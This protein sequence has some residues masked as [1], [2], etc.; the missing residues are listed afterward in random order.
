MPP[1]VFLCSLGGLDQAHPITVLCSALPSTQPFQD[2]D[3]RERHSRPDDVPGELREELY[4]ELESAERRELSREDEE[5][6]TGRLRDL[7]YL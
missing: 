3:P 6:V 1:G 5:L 7:G 4:A 2:E